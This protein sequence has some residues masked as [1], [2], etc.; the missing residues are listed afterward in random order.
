MSFFPGDA[1]LAASAFL[2]SQSFAVGN[3]LVGANPSDLSIERARRH[4]NTSVK[5]RFS[6]SKRKIFGARLAAHLVRL[7]LES[8]FLALGKAGKSSPLDGADV[9]EDV[10]SAI[11]G[12]NKAKTLLA[13]EPLHGT[14]RHFLLQSIFC[15]TIRAFSS[16]GRCL[17]EIA[18]RAHS[19][20]HSG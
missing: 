19:K 7:D 8:N 1:G 16:T 17:W 5:G 10:V 15:A 2:E 12:F 20:R 13:I 18:P 9:N 4:S 3:W 11:A 14:C 6:S